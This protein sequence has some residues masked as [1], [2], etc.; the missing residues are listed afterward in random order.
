MLGQRLI[1]EILSAIPLAAT[2]AQS[3]SK[4]ELKIKS[5]IL[6]NSKQTDCDGV[7]VLL[8]KT[9]GRPKKHQTAPLF[10][11]KEKTFYFPI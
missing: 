4:I 6:Q 9:F 5:N 1:S 11:Y 7:G 8:L 2:N 3:P 10:P